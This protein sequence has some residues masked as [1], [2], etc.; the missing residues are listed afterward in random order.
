ML[1]FNVGGPYNY[2]DDL[3]RVV[4]FNQDKQLDSHTR[5]E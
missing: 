5:T 4:Y 3:K 1:I 2:Q